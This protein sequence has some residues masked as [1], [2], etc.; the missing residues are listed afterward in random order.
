MMDLIMDDFLYELM[1]IFIGHNA[2]S[3][4]LIQLPLYL[5]AIK[6]KLNTFRIH[7]PVEVFPY[8]Y[9]DKIIEIIEIG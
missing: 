1:N 7:L 5:L 6:L 3:G 9:K 2:G 4:E 8:I